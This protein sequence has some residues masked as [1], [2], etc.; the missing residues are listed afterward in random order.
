MVSDTTVEFR[1]YPTSSCEING[2]PAVHGATRQLHGQ[3]HL[4]LALLCEELKSIIRSASHQHHPMVPLWFA[5]G[6]P[7]HGSSP[8]AASVCPSPLE[9]SNSKRQDTSWTALLE[10]TMRRRTELLRN[11]GRNSDA[12]T[13]VVRLTSKYCAVDSRGQSLTTL[14]LSQNVVVPFGSPRPRVQ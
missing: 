13:R 2:P 10:N 3:P 6:Y 1:I 12:F 9:L 14:N 8:D 4:V 11:L 7:Y 5:D